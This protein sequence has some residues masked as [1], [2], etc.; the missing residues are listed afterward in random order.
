MPF[1]DSGPLHLYFDEVGDPQDPPLLLIAGM[2]SQVLLFPEEFCLGLVDRGFFVVRI[3]NRDAG[4]SDR[5]DP[6]DEYTLS[7]M[8]GDVVAVMDALGLPAA[9]VL[10]MSLGG[11]IAQTVAIEHPDRTLS[12][13]SLSST[14]GNPAFGAPTEEALQAL[15]APTPADPAEAIE[16]DVAARRLWS[17]PSWFDE[18]AT[19]AYFAACAARSW[20]PEA[21]ARQMAAVVRSGSREERLAALAV[22]TLVVHGTLDALIAPSG[23]Q[24]TAALVPGAEL[25]EIEGMGHDLPVQAWQQIIT[26]V[27]ALAVRSAR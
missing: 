9:H 19:R 27:T 23:G 8:A 12:L 11:M 7:D 15:T 22:P 13:T 3:D 21:G 24:R 2:G 14:T 17:S 4:L 25:V 1:A 26:A 18:E 5:T 6:D 16:A 20:R 10:G